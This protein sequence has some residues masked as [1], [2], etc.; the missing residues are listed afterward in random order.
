MQFLLVGKEIAWVRAVDESDPKL[1]FANG[2]SYLVRTVEL[3]PGK[4]R[5]EILVDGE[6]VFRATYVPKGYEVFACYRGLGLCE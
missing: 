2:F 6:R 3:S 4:N 1:S 5:F